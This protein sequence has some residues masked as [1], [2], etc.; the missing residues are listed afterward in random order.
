MAIKELV[1]SFIKY[2]DMMCRRVWESIRQLTD[3]QFVTPIDYSHG[4]IRDLMIH[5]TAVDG[6]W[7][8]ALQGVPD[9]RTYSLNPQDYLDREDAYD[10]WNA[11]ARE[12]LNFTDS[13]DE[14]RLDETA[15]G[16]YGPTWQVLFH[17]VNHGTD[18][19]AQV[20]RAIHDF[21]GETFDQ[22]YILF[23]WFKN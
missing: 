16:M 10:I 13:L 12:L 4:S 17:L 8:R 15:I 6:R 1:Q 9:S 14:D 7:L 2:N 5:M 3:E 18:H 22:D 20:L 11:T 23:E 19:R 21:G